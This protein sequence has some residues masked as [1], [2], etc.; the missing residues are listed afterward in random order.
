VV[1][2]EGGGDAEKCGIQKKPRLKC[3]G[4]VVC[5]RATRFTCASR[6]VR[7]A[8]DRHADRPHLRKAAHGSRLL[9]KAALETRRPGVAGGEVRMGVGEA[10]IG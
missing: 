7:A 8:A 10:S 9:G 2:A 5:F 4:A 6:P 1:A 3:A